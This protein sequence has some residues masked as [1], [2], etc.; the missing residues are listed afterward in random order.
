MSFALGS[1]T[2]PC[3]DTLIELIA[4]ALGRCLTDNDINSMSKNPS[5]WLSDIHPKII[6]ALYCHMIGADRISVT[7]INEKLIEPITLYKGPKNKLIHCLSLDYCQTLF[8][9]E[10]MFKVENAKQVLLTFNYP[11][12]ITIGDSDQVG[13][14]KYTLSRPLTVK[15]L[16][17]YTIANH[18][19]YHYCL[20]KAYKTL[21]YTHSDMRTISKEFF[22]HQLITSTKDSKIANYVK[23]PKESTFNKDVE[24]TQI[25][26]YFIYGDGT[27][28]LN[29]KYKSDADNEDENTDDEE[30]DD[31]DMFDNENSTDEY[32]EDDAQFKA[33]S[34]MW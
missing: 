5:L 1:K 25:K 11:E 34:I 13:Y 10:P 31:D 6:L 26:S 28:I 27:S 24:N 8:Q 32:D 3:N 12:I 17:L 9:L 20:F 14:A 21:D 19:A 2:N 23:E 29:N 30:D 4:T 33:P 18:A 7:C 15:L 16:L 22:L